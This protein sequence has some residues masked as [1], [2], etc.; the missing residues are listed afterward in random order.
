MAKNME[1]FDSHHKVFSFA[2]HILAS[3]STISFSFL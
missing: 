1:S 2:D 3:Y